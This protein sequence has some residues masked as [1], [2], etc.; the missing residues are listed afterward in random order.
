M[1]ILHPASLLLLFLF[2]G[3]GNFYA[4]AQTENYLLEECYNFYHTG[5]YRAME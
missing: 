1:K 2:N 5:N 3:I 4:K